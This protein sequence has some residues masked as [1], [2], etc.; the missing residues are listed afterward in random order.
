MN[1]EVYRK[2][3]EAV[4]QYRVRI[5][6]QN[7]MAEERRMKN[8]LDSGLFAPLIPIEDTNKMLADA[9]A[10]GRNAAA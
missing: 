1:A 3:Q 7:Q 6:F 4:A 8:V 2:W 10:R 5:W 9:L